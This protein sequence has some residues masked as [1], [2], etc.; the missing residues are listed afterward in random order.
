MVVGGGKMRMSHTACKADGHFYTLYYKVK[1]RLYSSAYQL[2]WFELE[3]SN[4][5]LNL[6]IEA[7]E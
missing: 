5:F 3:L 4:P 7:L 2:A 1:T 6:L